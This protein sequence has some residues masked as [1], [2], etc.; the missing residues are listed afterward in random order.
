MVCKLGMSEKISQ[1]LIDQISTAINEAYDVALFRTS[2][3]YVLGSNI[4]SAYNGTEKGFL[5]VLKTSTWSLDEYTDQ[6][7]LKD[8]LGDEID[9]IDHPGRWI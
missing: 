5:C 3:G 4:A 8:H 9:Q 6:F 7:T 1:N 2:A